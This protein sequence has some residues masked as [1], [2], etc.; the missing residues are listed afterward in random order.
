M[1]QVSAELLVDQESLADQEH[2]ACQGRRVRRVGTES[3][4]RLESKE[5]LVSQVQ[6]KFLHF[7]LAGICVSDVEFS[8]LFTFVLL[9][10]AYSRASWLWRSR[11]SW[12][13]R[14]A[15]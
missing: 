8:V 6:I 2:R 9:L 14:V 13:S 15:R 4:A 1:P 11:S 10:I 5:S 3:Q 12:S 7:K